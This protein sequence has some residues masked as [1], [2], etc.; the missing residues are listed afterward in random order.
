MVTEKQKKNF[1]KKFIQG[2]S[3]ECWEWL[4]TKINSGYGKFLLGLAHRF[5]YEYFVG[6]IPEGLCV[7][8]KCD[9][10][11][12]VNPNHLFL[13]TH[14]DNTQDMYKKGRQGDC[15]RWG[16][17]NGNFGKDWSGEKN[18]NFGKHYNSL[19]FGGEKNNKAKL[20]WEKVNEI[21]NSNLTHEE[22]SKK[23]GVNK[24]SVRHVKNFVTWKI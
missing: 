13:G 22:L 23:F 16:E 19:R 17:K 15:R 12:C 5:A 3:D 10:P 6:P 18:P 7:L 14:K 20:N 4:G 24:Q 2:N 11:G 21:R 1:L 9:N 8:H